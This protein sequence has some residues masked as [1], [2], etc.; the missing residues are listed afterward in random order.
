MR[1]ITDFIDFRNL[2]KKTGRVNV[3]DEEIRSI[4][5]TCN[6]ARLKLHGYIRGDTKIIFVMEYRDIHICNRMD[7]QELLC[8]L[9]SINTEMIKLLED[10]IRIGVS[11]VERDEI[12]KKIKVLT[13]RKK[14][15]AQADEHRNDLGEPQPIEEVDRPIEYEEKYG[16]FFPIMEYPLSE[17][18]LW[19]VAGKFGQMRMEYIKERQ[20]TIYKTFLDM[21]RLH[22]IILETDEQAWELNTELVSDYRRRHKGTDTLEDIGICYRATSIADEI[23]I[24][25]IVERL[26]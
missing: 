8:E 14:Y 11:D 9:D 5:D 2:M 21:G 26:L 20:P 15:I 7:F 13:E 10:N 4:C 23:V 19:Q 18:Q 22:D 16:V 25:E 24:K 6:E 17:S 3:T 1:V 12:E